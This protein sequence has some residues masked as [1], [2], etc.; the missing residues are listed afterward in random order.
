[1]DEYLLFASAAWGNV[2]DAGLSR[3]EEELGIKLSKD[4]LKDMG[5]FI[6]EAKFDNGLIEHELDQ[7]LVGFVDLDIKIKINNTEL[8]IIAGKVF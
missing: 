1:M 6:Y 8:L 4:V 2:T 3:L 7:V 5:S